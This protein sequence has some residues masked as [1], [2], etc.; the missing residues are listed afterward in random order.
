[1]FEHGYGFPLRFPAHEL[2]TRVVERLQALLKSDT[3]IFDALDCAE[4]SPAVVHRLLAGAKKLSAQLT[5]S[6]TKTR[7]LLLNFLRKVTVHEDRIEL[8]IVA[9]DLSG[10]LAGSDVGA[11]KEFSGAAW[12][13][14]QTVC[15]TIEAKR[16]KRDG[17]LHL[18]VPST[19]TGDSTHPRPALIKALDRGYA[20]YQR[21]VEGGLVEVNTLA[22]EAGLTPT[23]VRNVLGFAFLAPDIVE[24]ILDGRQHPALKFA[25]LYRGIPHSWAE[26]RSVFGFP[27]VES[28]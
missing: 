1:M 18:V 22:Q 9:K 11:E 16:T 21:L 15:L 26:Q 24:A 17:A 20:W 4:K 28:R 27:A 13:V 10:I 12:N 25:D 6:E 14:N 23:Y 2:E 19:V 5:S 3:E 8:L 7:E